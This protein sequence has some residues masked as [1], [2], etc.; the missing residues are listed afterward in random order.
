VKVEIVS[1]LA[2]L[3]G[4]GLGVEDWRRHL[5]YRRKKRWGGDKFTKK[6]GFIQQVR[7]EGRFD[8]VYGK[9]EIYSP[10]ESGRLNSALKFLPLH[11]FCR[12]LLSVFGRG[13]S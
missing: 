2:T 3:R 7:E 4:F 9:F 13:Q 10:D 11:D 8:I 6:P 1:F 5:V 12:K